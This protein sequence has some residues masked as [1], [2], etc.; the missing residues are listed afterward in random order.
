MKYTLLLLLLSLS[1]YAQAQET[2]TLYMNGDTEWYD[3]NSKPCGSSLIHNG[4]VL[5]HKGKF[6]DLAKMLEFEWKQVDTNKY[7]FVSAKDKMEV[8]IYIEPLGRHKD[9]KYPSD[10]ASFTISSFDETFNYTSNNTRGSCTRFLS[11]L[12]PMIEAK[13]KRKEFVALE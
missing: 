5:K 9:A 3:T 12:L 7:Y 10:K 1:F 4:G 13:I 8:C 6:I 2:P 11:D